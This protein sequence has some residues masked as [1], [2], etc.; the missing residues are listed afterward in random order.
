MKLIRSNINIQSFS[1]N[2]G[3]DSGSVGSYNT[4]V[5]L[6]AGDCLVIVSFNINIAFSGGGSIGFQDAGGTVIYPNQNIT[7]APGGSSQWIYNF[8][9]GINILTSGFL[10]LVI[11]GAGYNAGKTI[12]DV[13]Y[14][15]RY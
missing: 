2:I 13:V 7:P 12:V 4:P 11:G 1:I 3:Q 14:T 10:Q 6:L 9:N 8:Q 5:E 15:R